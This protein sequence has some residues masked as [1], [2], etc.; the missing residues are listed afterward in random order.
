M[1][2]FAVA[3]KMGVSKKEA[4]D[5]ADQLLKIPSD[6][7][8]ELLLDVTAKVGVVLA[9]TLQNLAR[10]AAQAKKQGRDGR[11]AGGP[12]FAGTAYTVGEHGREVFTPATDGYITPHD[13]VNL[14][15]AA[16]DI[17]IELHNY[18]TV[19]DEQVVQVIRKKVRVGGGDVQRV[20]GAA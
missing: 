2:G 5:Y 15:A 6:V 9:P 18:M 4:K 13:K 14:S 20:L 16:Q 11:A 19:G 3:V 8:T 7:R 17:T 10:G 1:Q 12:V